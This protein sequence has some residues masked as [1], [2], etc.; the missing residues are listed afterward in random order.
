M[1]FATSAVCHA[2]DKRA[3]G[4]RVIDEAGFNATLAAALQV[5]D[6]ATD[7]A[8]GQHF[9]RMTASAHAFVSSGE[10]KRT[11]NPDDY[12]LREHRGVVSP[13]LR[14]EFAL[15]LEALAVVVYTVE[16][17]LADPEINTIPGEAERIQS[18]AAEGVTH[19]IVAVIASAA[20]HAP[21][22]PYRFTVALAGGN[23]EADDWTLEEVRRLASESVTYWDEWAIVA[24]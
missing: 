3:I 9:L 8:Q 12:V 17:Y 18:E 11:P 21:R 7:R 24:D 22:T 1:R 4:S 15:P 13:F 6:T 20:P 19:V 14:R 16:A 5:H 2:F 10:G 23:N